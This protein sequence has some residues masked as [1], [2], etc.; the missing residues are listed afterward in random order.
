MRGRWERVTESW[1]D[2]THDD[3]FTHTV[4]ISEPDAG[5]VVV[6]VARP[7]PTYEIREAHARALSGTFDR[8]VLEGCEN[9]AGVAMVT[10]SRQRTSRGCGT[11]AACLATQ[12]SSVVSGGRRS[13][14]S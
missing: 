12:P 13:R 2:N 6:A 4:R 11:R 1:I 9:L 10:P 3:A 7:S 8:A 14:G 5:V